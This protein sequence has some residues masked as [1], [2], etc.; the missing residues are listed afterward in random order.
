[1][2]RLNLK[3]FLI[4]LLFLVLE[5]NCLTG[6]QPKSTNLASQDNAGSQTSA[7]SESNAAEPKEWLR[8][9]IDLFSSVGDTEMRSFLD[10]IAVQT[11]EVNWSYETV[12]Q[13]DPER[14]NYLTN[15]RTEIMAGKG[16]DLFLCN[17]P[18]SKITGII[19]YPKQ[20]MN[21]HM[22]LPLDEYIDNAEYME[23]E[24]L[25]P[26]V[27][28]AGR[29]MEGQQLLPL[30]FEFNLRLFEKN[31]SLPAVNRPMNWEQMVQTNDKSIET[32]AKTGLLSDIF[33]ELANYDD[34]IAS[35]TEDALF[36]V[37]KD[38]LSLAF[39]EEGTGIYWVG[40]W[41]EGAADGDLLSLDE[42]GKEYF[43]LP[44]YNM[45][46]G[47]TANI[48]TF[49]AINRNTNY[50][51]ECFA[52]LDY[53]LSQKAQQHERIYQCMR[54]WPVHMDVGS[55]NSP[56]RSKYMSKENFSEFS[57]IRDQVNAVKFY[58]PLDDALNDISA[59]WYSK[60]QADNEL[61]KI[62]HKQYTTIQMMIAES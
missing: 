38:Y 44:S 49:A 55:K 8:I 41:F 29:N 37:T 2:Q 56:I 57:M 19:P 1:M 32:V 10:N 50:P 3:K 45:A 24:T 6:C 18:F 52:V 28:E 5:I 20:A 33:G 54:G 27:M 26:L 14:E 17:C 13:E 30:T 7:P 61:E 51:E 62:V 46:G 36:D 31:G 15:L 11:K 9:C 40:G 23:W 58:T 60:N 48:C 22:F 53:L 21:N 34:D 12:P 47:I 43:M 59:K 25:F 16:P 35:F 42:N 4:T 39:Y